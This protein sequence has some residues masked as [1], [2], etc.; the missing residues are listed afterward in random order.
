MDIV[1]RSAADSA[2]AD[3]VEY[4]NKNR[5]R[6]GGDNFLPNPNNKTFFMPINQSWVTVVVS[7]HDNEWL[8]LPRELEIIM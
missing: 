8:S 1:V 3:R 7:R 2:S 5:S 4:E 6:M